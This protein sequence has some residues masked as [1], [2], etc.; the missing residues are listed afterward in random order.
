MIAWRRLAFSL[1][2][3]ASAALLVLTLVRVAERGRFA[4]AYSSYGSGAQGT[5][6]LF[7]LLGELGYPLLRWSQDLA[8]LPPQSTLIALGSCQSPAAR[9]LSRYETTELVSFIE[10]G[11]VLLVAGA[12]NYLPAQLGVR[13]EDDAD[14]DASHREADEEVAEAVERARSEHKQQADA[15]QSLTADAGVPEPVVVPETLAANGGETVW[16]VPLTKSLEG[17]PIVQFEKPGKLHVE[18]FTLAEPLLAVPPASGAPAADVASMAITFTRGRGR[19]IVLSSASMLQNAELEGSEGATLFTRLLRSY[20]NPQLLIF[21]EY[22]LGLGER[23]SL[24]QYLRNAGAMPLIVQLLCVLACVLWRRGARLGTPQPTLRGAAAEPLGTV[25]FVTALG[26]LYRRVGD[27]GAAVR[28]IAR[29]ALLRVARHHALGNLKAS[30]LER[31]LTRRGA[32]RAAKAVREIV[33]AGSSPPTEPL[34]A[35]VKRIDLAV[36]AALADQE[37]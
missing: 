8:R 1:F 37:T 24:M 35:I 13:F 34:P 17:L 29:A 7:L 25:S 15:G 6:A 32:L 22:H 31:E 2:L 19:V 11:G 16:A 3:V 30:A 9:P 12:R 28:L 18:D 23:R 5:R 27:R 4:R 33:S 20:A 21:D 36:F 14:C 10:R 26:A